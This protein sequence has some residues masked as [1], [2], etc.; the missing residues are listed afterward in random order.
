MRL[1]ELFN[2][3]IVLEAEGDD[4]LG[5]P[6]ENVK[7]TVKMSVADLYMLMGKEIPRVKGA[8]RD[9][10]TVPDEYLKQVEYEVG[11]GEGQINPKLAAAHTNWTNAG[12]IPGC[13]DGSRYW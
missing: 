3:P 7:R 8:G 12:R 11:E 13:I 9:T 4:S 5:I 2:K 6:N 1:D 10:Y